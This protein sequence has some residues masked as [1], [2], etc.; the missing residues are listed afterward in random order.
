MTFLP[1]FGSS[2]AP[3]Q[4][5][6]RLAKIRE[7]VD[8]QLEA[9]GR[10]KGSVQIVASSRALMADPV[11]H[12]AQA[13]MRD[14]CEE[15]LPE[16]IAKRP[17]IDAKVPGVVWHYAGRF[18]PAKAKTTV[19]FFDW[20]HTIDRV[21]QVRALREAVAGR[22]RPL[23]VLIEVNP[24]GEAKRL[25]CSPQELPELI[26]ALR[27]LPGIQLEGLSL[28]TEHFMTPEST[29]DGFEKIKKIQIDMID[30]SILPEAASVLAMGSSRDY[31]AAVAAGS[32][33]LRLG[34][35]L[36]G[37]DA[38]RVMGGNPLE[39]FDL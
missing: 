27:D 7:E 21:T 3:S 25:G 14:F 23:H 32:T 11:T 38:Y 39:T 4:A 31:A 6:A 10:P 26:E 30:K 5:A 33:M 15:F 22:E 20:V 16:G 17:V 1:S 24:L 35:I 34:A 13:G 29:L 9:G 12:L 8:R 28:K 2:H 19:E 37:E 36:F 18:H